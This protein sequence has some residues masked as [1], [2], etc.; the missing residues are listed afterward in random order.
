[1]FAMSGN[2]EL[3]R[4][5]KRAKLAAVVPALSMY[6][7]LEEVMGREDNLLP[8]EPPEVRAKV[9]AAIARA[10]SRRPSTVSEAAQKSRPLALVEGDPS[11]RRGSSTGAAELA[12]SSSAL[13]A[14]A[15]DAAGLKRKVRRLSRA[16]L[17]VGLPTLAVIDI[18]PSD[19]ALLQ[20]RQIEVALDTEAGT[21]NDANG[22]ACSTSAE[23]SL[24]DLPTNFALV[25]DQ[26]SVLPRNRL[27]S[28]LLRICGGLSLPRASA[29]EA[30]G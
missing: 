21:D 19:I 8:S 17:T 20:G 13:V 2:T 5:L 29:A 18:K 14:V 30:K 24:E 12:S 25:D 16:S 10:L 1:M 4:V 28:K 23:V 6:S 7:T 15:N 11:N 22:R 26:C 9:K 27:N 3:S